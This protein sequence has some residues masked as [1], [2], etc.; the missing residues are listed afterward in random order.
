MLEEWSA[1]HGVD[2][3]LLEVHAIEGTGLAY[4]LD[5]AGTSR[6]VDAAIA[7][8]RA[9]GAQSVILGGAAF[10]SHA[11]SSSLSEP[12]IDCIAAATHEA[13]ASGKAARQKSALPIEPVRLTGLAAPLVVRIGQKFT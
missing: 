6:R 11:A 2:E 5:P 3:R 4:A 7:A 9:R 12:F 1:A 8:V 10:A 13:L